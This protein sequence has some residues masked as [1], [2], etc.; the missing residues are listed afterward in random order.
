MSEN[1]IKALEI[2][3]MGMVGIFTAIVV[4]VAFVWILQKMDS[5][6]SKK[7]SDEA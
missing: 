3:G 4:I 1:V 7:K 2:M 6:G 5:I